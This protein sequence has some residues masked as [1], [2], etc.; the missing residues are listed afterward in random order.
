[1]NTKCFAYMKFQDLILTVILNT[2][3]NDLLRL[4]KVS[5]CT[6]SIYFSSL[7]TDTYICGY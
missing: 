3:H 1:M 6:I 2:D 7:P 4:G 5:Y